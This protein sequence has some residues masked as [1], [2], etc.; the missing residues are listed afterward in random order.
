[1]AKSLGRLLGIRTILKY[2][3]IRRLE[4]CWKEA[5]VLGSLLGK[6]LDVG[7]RPVIAHSIHRVRIRVDCYGDATIDQSISQSVNV[8]EASN[9]MNIQLL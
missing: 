2:L 5:W 8:T 9:I 6:I 1:M 3:V 7:V 4:S